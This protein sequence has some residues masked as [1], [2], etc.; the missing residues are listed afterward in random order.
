VRSES[1][2][3]VATVAVLVVAASS[4]AVASPDGSASET[5]HTRADLPALDS[6]EPPTADGT[7]VVDGEEFDTAQA[8]VDAA[9]PGETV[10]LSGRFDERVTV[11]TPNVTITAEGPDTAMI[12][13][14]GEGDVLTVDA[15]GVTV[16]DV[17]LRN[18]GPDADT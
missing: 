10:R 7:A 14:G 13:G 2:F 6:F 15:S 11:R 8:A 3:V 12:D 18:S 1:T 17:W 9:E 4:V 16:E 5:V